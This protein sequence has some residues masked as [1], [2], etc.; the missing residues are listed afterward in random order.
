M[1]IVF[2]VLGLVAFGFFAGFIFCSILIGG[3]RADI[4]F[5]ESIIMDL[6]RQL[7]EAND[8]IFELSNQNANLKDSVY[9]YENY[10]TREAQ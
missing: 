8:T 10:K 6:N 5:H 4:T 2:T 3:E 1:E 9:F 7:D